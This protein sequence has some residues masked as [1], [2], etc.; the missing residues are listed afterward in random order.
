[1]NGIAESANVT[2]LRQKHLKCVERY[3]W[4]KTSEEEAERIAELDAIAREIWQHYNA[5]WRGYTSHRR[6]IE[7]MARLLWQCFW[8]MKRKRE[9][10]G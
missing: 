10:T 7:V 8:V 6:G 9:A 3:P 2:A 4:P 1:M 5:N